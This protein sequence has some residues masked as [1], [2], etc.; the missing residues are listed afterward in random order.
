MTQRATIL[1]AAVTHVGNVREHNE[2][3]W[4]FDESAGV[5]L[6][7]DGMG[8]HAA[9]EVASELAIKT[10]R[11]TWTSAAV[12]RAA[13]AWA[14][15]GTADAKRALLAA[16]RDGAHAAHRA[17]SS[18]ADADP[19]KKGM[20]TTFVGVMVVGGDAVLAHAGDSRAY[21]VREGI[22]MQ[23]TE[24][25]T[26]LAKLLG[27]G[28]DVDV[29]GDGARFKTML[30]NALGIG[31]EPHASTFLI[32]LTDGDRLLLCSDG[33]S[34]YVEEAEV[35]E[36]LSRA[37]NPQRAAQQLVDM[38]LTRGGQDN[39]TAIVLRVVEVGAHVR[40]AELLRKDDAASAA[41]G[42]YAKLTPQK[43][44][45]AQRIAIARDL[46]RG[47]I[48]PAHTLGDRVAWIVLE[49]EVERDGVRVGPGALLYPESLIPDRPMIE[50]DRLYRTAA[51]VRGLVLRSDD[52][53][54]VCADDPELAEPLLEGLTTAMSAS[55]AA[56][57][58]RLPRAAT[59]PTEPPSGGGPPSEGVPG[60]TE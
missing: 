23:L 17:I 25:H 43:R 24:D 55:A 34:E 53:Q 46:G 37:A 14:E 8:G 33:I 50:R 45:R 35:G 51:P 20:G 47:E 1:A 36:V 32:P 44:L 9:G 4:F 19:H 38:A 40:S 26:L 10:V 30:T 60:E 57:S 13:T 21:L 56:S 54:E 29:D 59:A 7:C 3:A 31:N 48:V 58:S 11:E 28:I 18:E 27:A 2:D 22:A 42:L 39:A 15:T 12:G 49:G 52:F 16:L 5:F 41:C 6:V